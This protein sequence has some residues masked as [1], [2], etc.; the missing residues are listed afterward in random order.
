MKKCKKL[1]RKISVFVLLAAM[2][3]SMAKPVSSYAQDEITEDREQSEAVQDKVVLPDDLTKEL[4]KTELE[5]KPKEITGTEEQDGENEEAPPKDAA[6]DTNK[7]VIEGFE[8]TQQGKTLKKGDTLEFILDAY[9]AD[10][11]IKTIRISL[12]SGS[13]WNTL[14]WD[15]N[16]WKHD[17]ST[18]Q[19]ICEYTLTSVNTEKVNITRVEVIDQNSNYAEWPMYEGNEYKY[20]FNTEEDEPIKVKTIE[21]EQNE[22]VLTEN[23]KGLMTFELEKAI[24]QSSF[25]VCFRHENG[26]SYQLSASRSDAEN[27]YEVEFEARYFANGKWKLDYA[28]IYE[29][30]FSRKLLIENPAAYS[31]TVEKAEEETDKEKPVIQSISM[32]KNGEICRAGDSVNITV[33]ATDN[34]KLSEYGSIHFNSTA[35]IS[36]G[37]KSVELQYD[38]EGKVYRGTWEITKDTYPCEW[39]VSSLSIY[40]GESN[41]A[42]DSKFTSEAG[43]PYYINVYNG[44]TFV[45]PSYNISISFMALNENGSWVS[46]QQIQ[47]DKVVRRQTLKELGITFPEVSVK[48]QDFEQVGWVD[49]SGNAVTDEMQIV[50]N[51]GYMTVYA[52]YDKVL[53]EASYNY[54]SEN[55]G[56][57]YNRVTKAYPDGTT[58]GE[59]KADFIKAEAPQDNHKE[60]TF[61]GWKVQSSSRYE[62]D[63]PLRS[64][65]NYLSLSAEYDKDFVR[66]YYSYP[67]KDG[68]WVSNAENP[69][70]MEKGK[71]YKEALDEARKYRPKDLKTES[72]E[73]WVCQDMINEDSPVSS[74]A[75]IFFNAKYEGKMAL[76]VYRFYYNEEGRRTNQ[77]DVIFANDGAGKE[78]VQKLLDGLDTPEMYKDLRF[79]G[80]EA[81]DTEIFNS[82]SIRVN[83][84]YENFIVRY[85]IDPIFSTDTYTYGYD[86]SSLETVVC[87][88]A[89]PGEVVSIP[90]SFDGYENVTWVY[91]PADTDTF[92]VIQHMTFMGYGQ[93][94]GEEPSTPVE[95][96]DP[97]PEQPEIPEIPEIP[98]PE[99]PVDPSIPAVGTR[100][101]PELIESVVNSID[102]TPEGETIQVDMGSATTVPKEILESAKGKD[103]DIQLNM[104]GYSWTING[105]DILSKN[106]K[107]INL[108]V[109]MNT[110]NI[111]NATIQKLAGDNPVKQLSLAHEGDFGF[112]ASLTVKM[113]EEYAGRYGNLFYHDSAG[114]MTFIDAGTIRPDGMV[115]LGFSHASDYLVVMSKDKMAQSSVPSGMQPTGNNGN[116][117]GSSNGSSSNVRRSAKTGDSNEIMMLIL[118]S[119]LALG[120]IVYIKRRKIA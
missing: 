32:D 93:K 40:D 5:E 63:E 55:G 115:T 1:S 106:L 82:A 42:D 103:V 59:V 7:P 70:I 109:I 41:Y 74:D 98:K 76:V 22:K 35:D 104:D 13:D 8:F 31:F 49:Y 27:I 18:N 105:K 44:T 84:E 83:A 79:K 28:E 68:G 90:E 11:G 71:T 37:Y 88:V 95:P 10:S 16:E 92:E 45:Q 47:K 75:T 25:S 23:D 81:I 4:E 97:K 110:D 94:T 100:P 34:E 67:N 78:E 108:Q 46:I 19:Y 117:N 66:F 99:Q 119:M 30:T 61:Q 20:W 112:K 102:I 14:Y 65:M 54:V 64:S 56:Y 60:L 72:F 51:M 111:P 114:K 39:Y 113:G 50:E 52:K 73:K 9:D 62:D 36:D 96:E 43:Y 21:F 24:E 118:C 33:E 58:Y 6:Y 2:L 80:W 48:Y 116:A 53:V 38:E 77:Q 17:E 91:R 120:V 89:E 86:E 29:G 26:N 3:F 101:S 87:Q 107:D 57:G 15:S 12:N 69:M 85:L